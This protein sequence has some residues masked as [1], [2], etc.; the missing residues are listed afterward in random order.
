LLQGLTGGG[1]SAYLYT[2]AHEL[3]RITPILIV[4]FHLSH[5][6]QAGTQLSLQLGGCLLFWDLLGLAVSVTVGGFVCFSDLPS[7]QAWDQ[8]RG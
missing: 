5:S 7:P 2:G 4:L 6:W 8:G 3:R 1:A